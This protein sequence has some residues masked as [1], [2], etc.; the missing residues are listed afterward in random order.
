MGNVS[1]GLAA[2]SATYR[3]MDADAEKA[4]EYIN[5]G[6]RRRTGLKGNAMTVYS[7]E[8]DSWYNS[9]PGP[10]KSVLHSPY[11]K[12]SDALHWVTGDPDKVAAP[13]R[14]TSARAT[15]S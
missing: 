10:V 7:N 14:R 12:I 4:A 5:A 15:T 11:T 2:T 8:L 3:V 1:N 13:A 9:C 6:A